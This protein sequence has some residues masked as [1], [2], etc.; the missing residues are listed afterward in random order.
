MKDDLSLPRTISFNQTAL[1][2][3]ILLG[4]LAIAVL[5]FLLPIYSKQLGAS[6]TEIGGLFSIFF[7]VTMLARPVVGWGLDRL[8]R[9]P[10]LVVALLVY[11]LS[12]ALFA[13]ANDLPL[14]YT[15]RL[16]QGLGSSLLWIPAYTIAT[17]LSESG[18]GRAVGLVD[19][20]SAQGG[21]IGA[22]A[23]LA[24]FF[25][26][27]L[28]TGWKLLFAAYSLAALSAAILAF[29]SLPETRSSVQPSADSRVIAVGPLL[30]LMLIV[31]T[32]GVS[33]AMVSPLVLV[34]LQDRFTMDLRYLAMAYI[35]A[36]LAYSFLPPRFG[37]LSDRFDRPR[38]IAVGLMS[39]AVV[40]LL[41]P[42]APGILW[43]AVLWV[44]EAAGFS[45]ASPAQE[46]L[47]ADLTGSQVRGQGYGLYTFASSLGATLGP[48]LGGWLYDAA[49]HAAPF[50]VNGFILLFSAVW[51][52][53][54]LRK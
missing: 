37:R 34:F 38:M 30:R 52:L 33:T 9:K 11:A 46:A 25:S 12:L 42:I 24:L 7:V 22:L 15:A 44:L 27:S 50:Y 2:R 18:R 19:A 54:W 43:L 10:F 35:P 40:S 26:V 3:S 1:L 21:M 14:L 29:R 28:D 31:F 45:L 39:A 47:V 49:G 8:G 16:V 13:F 4:S 36:G 41:I 6:A 5:N 53:I 48:L 51:V 32:T 20:A 23:G 17:E